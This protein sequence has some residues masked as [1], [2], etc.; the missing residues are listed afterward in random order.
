[1][2]YVYILKSIKFRRLYIGY[3]NDLRKRFK[4]HNDG[5]TKSTKPYLPWKIIYYEAYEFKADAI[6]R[7]KQLK[8]YGKAYSGLKRRLQKSLKES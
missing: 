6:N 5:K 8:Y 7:E 3:T 2:Y 4:E 1:M